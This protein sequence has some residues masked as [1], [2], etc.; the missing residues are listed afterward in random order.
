MKKIPLTLSPNQ[1]FALEKLLN[2]LQDF[3]ATNAAGFS[4]KSAC[5]DVAELVHRKYRKACGELDIFNEKKKI[6]VDLKYHEA[7]HLL[8][9]II[10]SGLVMNLPFELQTIKNFLDQK[11]A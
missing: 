6:K 7:Y 5:L 3:I 2:Q 1:L 11:L 10:L 4:M 9:Y 8:Q